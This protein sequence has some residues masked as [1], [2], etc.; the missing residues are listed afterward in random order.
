MSIRVVLW[1]VSASLL[2]LAFQRTG[3]HAQQKTPPANVRTGSTYRRRRLR[4]A[5][6]WP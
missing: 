3:V 5:S 6:S 4:Y 2:A 1:V